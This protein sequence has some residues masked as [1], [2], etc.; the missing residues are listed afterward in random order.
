MLSEIKFPLSCGKG[1]VYL[2][3]RH[4][5]SSKSLLALDRE[6]RAVMVKQHFRGLEKHVSGM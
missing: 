5:D 2:S 1:V 4:V 3:F 6:L